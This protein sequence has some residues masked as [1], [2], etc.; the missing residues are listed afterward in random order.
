MNY[1]ISVIVPFFYSNFVESSE[2]KNFSLLSFDKCLSSIFK[3]DYKNFEVLAVSDNS[4][5]ESLKIASK[6]PCKI[7]K[8]KKNHGAAFSRNKGAYFANGKILV[9]LDSD[10]EIKTNALSIINN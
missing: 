10:V 8:S 3:S 4:S 1:K 9:F 6:Y 5:K 7:I 2:D